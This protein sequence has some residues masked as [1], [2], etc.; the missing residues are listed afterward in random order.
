MFARACA[1]A[2][3]HSWSCSAVP[4]AQPIA[5]IMVLEC[6]NGTPPG[7]VMRGSVTADETI[8]QKVCPVPA[9]S[10]ICFVVRLN[11]A[12]ATAFALD[13]S[14]VRNPVPSARSVRISRPD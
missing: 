13:V 2:L 10:A 6:V 9:F 11:A 4:P 12:E 14:G 5:P 7:V 8:D 1:P 3:A